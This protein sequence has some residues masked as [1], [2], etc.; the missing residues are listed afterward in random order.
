MCPTGIDT[1]PIM[2]FSEQLKRPGAC[3]PPLTTPETFSVWGT[4][5]TVAE[6]PFEGLT[7][8]RPAHE[9]SVCPSTCSPRA[10]LPVGCLPEMQ[11]GLQR[12]FF[13]LIKLL[14]IN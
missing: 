9:V 7:R 10:L 6:G 12:L 1:S 14:L 13:F 4:S 3:R 2:P 5:R 11:L 8:G